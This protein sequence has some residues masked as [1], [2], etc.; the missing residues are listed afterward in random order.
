[1]GQYGD[2]NMKAD[3]NKI[4]NVGNMEHKTKGRHGKMSVV[5]INQ[6]MNEQCKYINKCN[7][8]S[9]EKL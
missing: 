8:L 4:I 1:M 7:A 5:C 2:Y 9:Y 3:V 6:N